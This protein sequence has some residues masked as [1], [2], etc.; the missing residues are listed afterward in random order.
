[1]ISHPSL[2]ASG[3]RSR[4]ERLAF[5]IGGDNEFVQSLVKTNAH[6]TRLKAGANSATR[7]LVLGVR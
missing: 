5:V 2:L 7:S 1:M 4:D 3:A 6:A